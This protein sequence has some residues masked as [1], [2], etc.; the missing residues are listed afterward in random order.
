MKRNKKEVRV[1]L[2]PGT[3][4]AI[5]HENQANVVSNPSNRVGRSQSNDIETTRIGVRGVSKTLRYCNMR[6]NPQQI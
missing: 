1:P 6:V 4:W 5:K 3:V 2:A